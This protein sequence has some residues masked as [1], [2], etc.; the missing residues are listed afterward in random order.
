MPVV[1]IPLDTLYRL[2]GRIIPKEELFDHLTGIGNDVE[3]YFQVVRLKCA[4]CEEIYELM[5][6][7]E[8][9]GVCVSCGAELTPGKTLFDI[10][11][12]EVVR[13]E[14]M[15]AR[16]DMFDVGGLA[17]ALR[18][19]LGIEI[20]IP[21]YELSSSGITVNVG[22]PVKSIRPFI[23]CAVVRGMKLD[24][25]MIKTVMKMQENLHWAL[26]RDRRKAS[27]GVYDLAALKPD[28]EYTAFEK[29]EL[30]FVPLGGMPGE[31][32]RPALLVDIL[33]HHPKGTA[34]KHLLEEFESYP[35]LRDSAGQVLS[36]PPI[37]N[38]EETK[39]CMETE[40]FFVDVTG[41]DMRS[42][43][44][45]LNVLVCSL[46]ELGGR[47]ETVRIRDGKQKTETPDLKP[48]ASELDPAHASR[49]IG[50]DIS[51]GS[52]AELLSKMRFG[53]RV[54]DKRVSVSVPAYRTDIMHEYDLIEDIAIAYG[55]NNIEHALVPTLTVGVESALENLSDHYRRAASGLGFLEV[56]TTMLSNPG[57]NYELLRREDDGTGAI[58]ENPA[59]TEH[60]M[61][62]THLVSGLLEVFKRNRT[63]KMPQKIFELGDVT[64][65]DK[66]GETGTADRRFL[67]AAIMDPKTGFAEIKSCAEAVLRE[68]GYQL[69][70]EAREHPTFIPGRCAAVVFEGEELGVLGEI[71]PEV[72][73]NFETVPPVSLVHLSVREAPTPNPSSRER[74]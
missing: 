4:V 10:G 50:I 6:Q 45:T 74:P 71:H 41:H 68:L 14:L 65:V 19:Y 73:D 9:P 44:R 23:V 42:V 7:E 67:A 20:G 28:F 61:L 47:I 22:K 58:I 35:I 37:I 32:L 60:S 8:V 30:E 24:T 21:Q 55:Y 16:P 25:E 36:M 1:G 34:Y 3:G 5:A 43:E 46:A 54:Q 31:G 15:P 11:S 29:T 17:R 72:L 2:L 26:G 63:H 38:S 64:I 66:K 27:I 12:S 62:R 69:V 53:A 18:G 56:V 39:A 48:W 51:A 52:C 49:L 70:L 59:T 33:E 13:M 40:D 57:K